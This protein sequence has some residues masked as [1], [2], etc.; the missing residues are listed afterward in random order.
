[1]KQI[2]P[3]L[4]KWI[5]SLL[6]LFSISAMSPPNLAHADYDPWLGIGLGFNNYT[7]ADINDLGNV[8]VYNWGA[9]NTHSNFPPTDDNTEGYTYSNNPD[10]DFE[11]RYVPTIYGCDVGGEGGIDDVFNWVAKNN[12]VGPMIVF[13]EP[14]NQTMYS[15]SV[16]LVNNQKV[17]NMAKAVNA[18]E[19]I[20]SKRDTYYAN[21]GNYVDL[22]IG[23]T[24]ASPNNNW[25]WWNYDSSPQNLSPWDKGFWFDLFLT[26]WENQHGTG[27]WPNVE[28]VHIHSYHLYAFGNQS[29]AYIN[30][31][32]ENFTGSL[33]D[34]N[35]VGWNEWLDN[36]PQ[37]YGNKNM[38]WITESG[39]LDGT[40]S[41][42]NV[43]TVMNA[44]LPFYRNNTPYIGRVAWYTHT[45]NNYFRSSNKNTSLIDNLDKTKTTLWNTYQ[46]YCTDSQWCLD[47]NSQL[48]VVD[49]TFPTNLVTDYQYGNNTSNCPAGEWC[50]GR[51]IKF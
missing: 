20:V 25:D 45:T 26:E 48:G 3:S 23:G 44:V 31:L 5:F 37:A 6:L 46:D 8:W 27:T 43:N 51:H 35:D 29:A 47:D 2:F 7:K 28:G 36:H 9:G 10:V 4:P 15:C 22:L 24:Y 38:V 33:N 1:M 39:I 14:D 49:Y 41:T 50:G 21:T 13:N 12:Y 18:V 42:A 30:A 32:K 16:D 17:L 11:G 40:V 19:Y 34:P